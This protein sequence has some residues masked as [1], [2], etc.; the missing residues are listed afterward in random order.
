[1]IFRNIFLYIVVFFLFPLSGFSTEADVNKPHGF[2][3]GSSKKEVVK[4]IEDSNKVILENEKDSKDVRRIVFD[5]SIV[6]LPI[7]KTVQHET[8]LEFFKKKLMSS[9]LNY[10]FN[11]DSEL[12]NAVEEYLNY[13]KTHYGEASES[14]KM[15][16]YEL[17]T[18]RF[19]DIKILLNSNVKNKSLT[20]EYL[21]EPV[22]NK[23]IAKE[24]KDKRKTP[25]GDPAK[26]MF[27]E[28][29]YSRPKY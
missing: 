23:K 2:E 18:W 22:R 5:G 6:D 7:S 29:T 26:E 17:W 12:M 19:P 16:S 9:A 8:R 24:L 11:D 28:G 13:I 4:I 14:E 21:Y 20:I 27:L 3:F 15:L 25:V 10:K 1:M